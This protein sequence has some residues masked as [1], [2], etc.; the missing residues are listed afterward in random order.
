MLNEN[1][2]VGDIDSHI[3]VDD[4]SGDYFSIAYSNLLAAKNDSKN[5]HHDIIQCCVFSFLSL[6]SAINRAY[7]DI[8]WRVDP[9]KIPL[10]SGIPLAL[11]NDIKNNWEHFPIRKKYLILPTL[12][13]ESKYSEDKSPFLGGVKPFSLFS[14][15]VTFRNNLVHANMSQITYTVKVSSVDGNSIQGDVLS[16]NILGKKQKFPITGFSTSF[17]EISVGDAEKA[18]EITYLMLNDLYKK[19]HSFSPIIIFMNNEGKC[20]IKNPHISNKIL[21]S[22]EETE[23]FKTRFSE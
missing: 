8:F 1:N 7:Y 9:P 22:D 3:C 13:T 14:E 4:P 12:I 2:E 16:S 19:T 18:F 17:H 20:E 5:L 10:N 6:E 23:L 11:S 15:F 21:Y